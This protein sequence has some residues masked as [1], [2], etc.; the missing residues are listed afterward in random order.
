MSWLQNS[1]VQLE[2]VGLACSFSTSGQQVEGWIMPDGV[3][4]FQQNGIMVESHPGSIA[5]HHVEGLLLARQG[6]GNRHFDS[7]DLGFTLV[8][9]CNWS[10]AGDQWLKQVSAELAGIRGVLA[11]YVTFKADSAE[12]ESFYTEFQSNSHAHHHGSNNIRRGSVG[13][14]LSVGEVVRTASGRHSSPFPKIDTGNERRSANTLK[15]V[16]QWLI[17]NALDEATA[18]GDGF[19]ATQFKACLEKPQQADKDAAEEY[20][21]GTEVSANCVNG[22]SE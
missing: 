8:D 20:L 21:F 16:D 15:R 17:Q 14:M 11:I 1:T 3:G 2:Q 6:A 5:T 18:R 13:S 22:K 10:A 19:N 12:L 9:Q 7:H 4:V